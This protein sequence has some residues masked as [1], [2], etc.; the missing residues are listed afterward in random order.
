MQMTLL[1]WFVLDLTGSPWLVSLVGFFTW[2]PLVPLGPIGG[3]LADSVDR[4]KLLTAT[5]ASTL[6][7]A[8]AMTALLYSGRVQYWHAYPTMLVAGAA[9]ALAMPLR[10]SAIHDLL[11]RSGVTNGIALDSVGMSVS[12]M[13]GP[14]LAGAM[15]TVAGVS[16]GYVVVTLLYLASVLLLSRL[17]LPRRKRDGNSAPSLVSN[18]VAGLRYIAGHRTLLGVFQITVLM[19]LLLYPYTYMVPVI[20]KNDLLV[21]PGLMGLLMASSGLGSMI[22]A[23]GLASLFDIR[24][25]G[26][27]LMSGALIALL[28]LLLFSFSS[29][30]LVSLSVLIVLGVGSAG[31]STM[32][33]T[34]TMLLTRDE[35]RGTMLG[36]VSLATGVGPLGALMVG[37]VAASV[38]PSFALALNAVIGLTWLGLVAL[39]MPSLRRQTVS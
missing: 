30:Y 24:H 3:V 14:A 25:H 28:A 11:G 31:F 35:I 33:S 9:W 1:A 34:L 19:P 15:I 29:S 10:R 39:L 5:H 26:R 16:G 13:L 18:V 21:G 37:A 4:R 7:A 2:A 20:A 8:L 6:A 12:M 22:G 17:R 27:I 36:I 32:F 23:V 38:S